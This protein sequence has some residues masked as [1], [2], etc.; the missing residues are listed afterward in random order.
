MNA[1][2][3]RIPDCKKRFYIDL[4]F[5]SMRIVLV[6]DIMNEIKA[7]TEF[8]IRQNPQ[9][10]T[11]L[12]DD[13]LAV[14]SVREMLLICSIVK[15]SFF[16]RTDENGFPYEYRP[17]LM[18]S[19]ESEWAVDLKKSDPALFKSPKILRFVQSW[20]QPGGYANRSYGEKRKREMLSQFNTNSR[21]AG[22]PP[23]DVLYIPQ[24]QYSSKGLT[25]QFDE[26]FYHYLFGSVLRSMGYLVLDEYVPY[27]FTAKIPDLSAFRTVEV[28]D[29]LS[30]LDKRGF[31]RRGAFMTELQTLNITERAV[32]GA[33]IS[34][35]TIAEAESLLVEVKRSEKIK[36]GFDSVMEYLIAGYG[37]YD[38][39]Y[40]AAPFIRDED[41]SLNTFGFGVL[42]LD[43]KGKL[44]FKK[45]KRMSTPKPSDLLLSNRR[46]QLWQVRA[47]LVLQLA[48]N[49]PLDKLLKTC[50][51]TRS[52]ATYRELLECLIQMDPEELVDLIESQEH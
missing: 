29:Y 25:Y 41:I 27:M 19:F 20:L 49:V 52:V 45:A 7:V 34:E 50:S 10:F 17:S 37:L 32:L 26:S 18:D 28:R 4:F 16:I 39:G 23:E 46:N 8:L 6:D 36:E 31:I 51:Q 47:T 33:G 38:D 44:V 48:K 13:A 5:Y 3:D 14:N 22:Y 9:T 40:L 11:R 2:P 42:S 30:V 43:E 35:P 24:Q 12:S 21:D 15:S 1:Y